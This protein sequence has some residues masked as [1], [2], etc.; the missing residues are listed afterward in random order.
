MKAKNFAI[1]GVSG[2]I[3]KRHLYA[4]KRLKHNL[5]ISFD[6]SDSVG[7]LDKYFPNCLFFNNFSNFKKKI[8][9]LKKKIDYL[10]ILTPNYTHF[11]YIKFA[12]SNGLNVICEKPLV[13][14]INH[15][16]KI[17][18][19]KKK[20]E[21]KVYTILQIRNLSIINKLKKK[22]SSTKKFFQVKVK[23]IT[24]RGKWYQNTWKGN[25]SKSGGI[26]FN[27]G[28]HLIDVLAYLFEEVKSFKLITIKKD[29][30]NSI[31]YFKNARVNF[32][33]STNPKYLK[34]YDTNKAIRELIIN[35]KKINLS[36]NFELAHLEC[37]KKILQDKYF[38][39]DSIRKGIELA[40]L[41]KK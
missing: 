25:E 21:R 32:F 13:L 9:S 5:L 11:F 15:L 2:F 4:I 3:A 27:I 8:I 16:N 36:Y 12:L 39:F 20:Y 22:I 7:I 14:T 18:L 10:V 17:E 28:I 40:L 24:P 29:L 41:L 30:L 31:I 34:L 33:L 38:S 23:Y 26:L 19:L 35:K 1:I 6:K 37:Y